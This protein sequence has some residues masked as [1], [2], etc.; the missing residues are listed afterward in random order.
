MKA[1]FL[2]KNGHA[3]KAF[4]L[5]ETA[6]P[7]ISIGQVLIRVE[8]FGLNF[9]DVMARKGLYPEAP[10]KPAILGYDVVG[11][12]EE[13]STELDRKLIGKRVLAL[14][15]FGGYA[16]YVSTDINGVVIIPEDMPVGIATALATQAATAVYM[17]EELIRMHKGEHVLIHSAAG[18][19]GSI[20]VQLAL[21]HGCYVHA[22]AGGKQKIQR[23][24]DMGVHHAIDYVYEDFEKTVKKRLSEIPK[25][26][27]D[28]VFDAVGGKSIKKGVKLLGA[29]GRMIMYGASAFTSAR[30]IFG[31]L[32][33]LLGFGFY[34]P[35]GLL[36]PSKSLLAI[37]MLQI[38]DKQPE[39]LN[40]VLRKSVDL[41]DQKVISPYIG[42]VYPYTELA[43]AHE[44]LGQ[45]DTMG[46]ITIQW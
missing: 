31:Q 19:V 15:R 16:E 28:V 14:T 21:H 36:N 39:V 40:R 43:E 1:Y 46:K 30:N 42:G 8:A 38:A 4:E 37:N 25:D 12:V 32:S 41:A 11:R 6:I 10:K 33:T 18:G 5:R 13:I 34:H 22:T 9:A 44:K 17:T 20:L 24:H 35:L 3:D 26:G 2:V 45:R 29:G 27:V 7:S 23:L